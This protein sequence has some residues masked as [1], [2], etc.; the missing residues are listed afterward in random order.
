M[1]TE[2]EKE[3]WGDQHVHGIAVGVQLKKF[4]LRPL[5]FPRRLIAREWGRSLG[6]DIIVVEALH[7][8]LAV[9]PL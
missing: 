3:M 8:I 1:L 2:E 5:G 4:V 7:G 6:I 9:S